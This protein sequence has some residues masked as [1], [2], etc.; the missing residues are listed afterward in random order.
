MYFICRVVLDRG[1]LHLGKY[2][3]TLN[4]KTRGR[5]QQPF[6]EFRQQTLFILY[7]KCVKCAAIILT[8][9]AFRFTEAVSCSTLLPCAVYCV[10]SI[11]ITFFFEQNSETQTPAISNIITNNILAVIHAEWR[12]ILMC[13]GSFIQNQIFYSSLSLLGHKYPITS[14]QQRNTKF[15]S[16]FKQSDRTFIFVL[17]IMNPLSEH[18]VHQIWK[19]STVWHTFFSLNTCSLYCTVNP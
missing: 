17:I 4:C 16:W 19:L 8:F 10:I 2:G 13:Y 9:Y 5:W 14:L 6:F 18:Y 11:T 1:I 3:N 15:N 12:T 7:V